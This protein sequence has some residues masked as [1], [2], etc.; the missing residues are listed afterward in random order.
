MSRLIT[1]P[2]FFFPL[3]LIGMFCAAVSVSSWV[4]GLQ[5]LAIVV[6]FGGIVGARMGFTWLPIAFRDALIVL[7]LYA[8]FV[9]SGAAS[10]SLARMPVDLALA[11]GALLAW[12]TISLFNPQGLSGLQLLIGLKVWLFYIPF[13]LIG[14]ALAARPHGLFKIFRVL[15]VCGLVACAVGLL[16][17]MLI[18]V[19]GYQSAISLFFGPAAASVTCSAI[20]TTCSGA[21]R[22][23]P[24]RCRAS[25]V[26]RGRT[27]RSSW[28]ST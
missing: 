27:T 24:N 8:A 22:S 19:I 3:L 23:S 4:R 20:P 17:A 13:F 10:D 21:S 26:W 14:I 2:E 5:L 12:L 18:R 28:P 15:L 7:P 11:L 6:L 16:Q 1:A 9:F 25:S